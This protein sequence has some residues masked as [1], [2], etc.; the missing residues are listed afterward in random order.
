MFSDLAHLTKMVIRL[1]L[2][3][4]KKSAWALCELGSSFKL[5]TDA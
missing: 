1:W 5:L 3:V 4:D 2:Y